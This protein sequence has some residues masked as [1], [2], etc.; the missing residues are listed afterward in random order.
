MN[1][2]THYVALQTRV[3]EARKTRH[4]LIAVQ[5]GSRLINMDSQA[6]NAAVKTWLLQGGHG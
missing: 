1:Q 5:K 6:P 3:E 4:D 2:Q